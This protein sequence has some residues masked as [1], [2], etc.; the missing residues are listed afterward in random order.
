MFIHFPHKRVVLTNGN[1]YPY[2]TDLY[3]RKWME[4]Y[5][6]RVTTTPRDIFFKFWNRKEI[7][8]GRIEGI[9]YS[10]CLFHWVICDKKPGRLH[11]KG[12]G[13]THASC[14]RETYEFCTCLLCPLKYVTAYILHISAARTLKK[15]WSHQYLTP[16][17]TFFLPYAF[18]ALQFLMDLEDQNLP[19]G[20]APEAGFTFSN[21]GM[22]DLGCPARNIR[23]G[24]Q[25]GIGDLD[26]ASPAEANR[27]F[28]ETKQALGQL[29]ETLQNYEDAFEGGLFHCA[30]ACH[31]KGAWL[32]L[33]WAHLGMKGGE[34]DLSRLETPQQRVAAHSRDL[35]PP[36][37]VEKVVIASQSGTSCIEHGCGNVCQGSYCNMTKASEAAKRLLKEIQQ[38]VNELCLLSRKPEFLE[39]AAV[40]GELKLARETWERGQEFWI[41]ISSQTHFIRATPFHL[42]GR[43]LGVRTHGGAPLMTLQSLAEALNSGFKTTIK[44][45]SQSFGLGD[46][47][48]RL[49][50]K[51]NL[52][53]LREARPYPFAHEAATTAASP[54]K[55]EPREFKKVEMLECEDTPALPPPIKEPTIPRDNPGNQGQLQRD[56]TKQK[57]RSEPKTTPAQAGPD[58]TK[59]GGQNSRAPKSDVIHGSGHRERK[60]DE[61]EPKQVRSD[62]T[63]KTNTNLHQSDKSN[64]SKQKRVSRK[65]GE[66][67]VN[68]I[69]TFRKGSTNLHDFLL[70]RPY[71]DMDLWQGRNLLGIDYHKWL[72]DK[73]RHLFFGKWD[74]D[75]IWSNPTNVGEGIIQELPL[76]GRTDLVHYQGVNFL[77]IPGQM[78]AELQ[79]VVNQSNGDAQQGLLTMVGYWLRF[80]QRCIGSYQEPLKCELCIP[81]YSH[82]ILYSFQSLAIHLRKVHH[83]EVEACLQRQWR[84]YKDQRGYIKDGAEWERAA[85]AV[86]RRLDA[87]YGVGPGLPNSSGLGQPRPWPEENRIS[88]PKEQSHSRQEENRISRPK[89]RK[90]K[91][92][93]DAPIDSNQSSKRAKA[94]LEQGASQPRRHSLPRVT[95]RTDDSGH[96]TSH[97]PNLTKKAQVKLRKLELPNITLCDKDMEEDLWG[98]H[99]ERAESR[100]SWAGV[101]CEIPLPGDPTQ[102]AAEAEQTLD[103][104]PTFDELI[105]ADDLES[106]YSTSVS[107][108]SCADL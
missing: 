108:G 90:K 106:Y 67:R 98:R 28:Y 65:E 41:R 69:P 39:R 99:Q 49:V 84:D 36:E 9:I 17:H 96:E 55:A 34:R 6:Q 101:N 21:R 87:H 32:V 44:E 14:D 26:F 5:K 38:G 102:G 29:G 37:L 103:P 105:P 76:P 10:E 22:T 104:V 31:G 60:S 91:A 77:K 92:V 107:Q 93:T 88:R 82:T 53:D 72:G 13:G 45:F 42:E 3:M 75:G 15:N 35:I 19:D 74:Q 40:L 97:F 23:L 100:A 52:P 43:K 71:V 12:C 89:E 80:L 83:L 4:P 63:S 94:E 7:I 56:H 47:F 61:A 27:Y 81:K 1:S 78:A 51:R 8:T 86:K 59:R 46:H 25:Q 58:P 33:V 30:A 64:G 66:P 57:R 50:K 95:Q 79:R 68:R 54:Q 85:L 2:P 48:E 18:H 11:R 70:G 20:Q 24:L 62:A 16:F 73:K